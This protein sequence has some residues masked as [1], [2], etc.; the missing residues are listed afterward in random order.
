MTYSPSYQNEKKS[1]ELKSRMQRIKSKLSSHFI[2][3]SNPIKYSF[4]GQLE[5]ISRSGALLSMR[6]P[7]TMASPYEKLLTP[8]KLGFLQITPDNEYL[9]TPIV[10]VRITRSQWKDHTFQVAFSFLEMKSDL[11]LLLQDVEKS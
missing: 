8:G 6:Q 9:D 4:Q 7:E 11:S 2:L 10:G 5:N 3:D 1:Q